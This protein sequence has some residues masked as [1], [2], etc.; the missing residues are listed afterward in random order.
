[1]SES[2]K[3]W[4][5]FV[6]LPSPNVS[7][8]ELQAKVIPGRKTDYIAKGA[9]GEPIVML[10]VPSFHTAKPSL[11]LRHI[12]IEY[13]QE[14]RI[15]EEGQPIVVGQF[16]AIACSS[17]NPALY[18]LFV[19]SADALVG[20][21]PIE[22]TAAQVEGCVKAFVELFRRLQHPGLRTIKGLWAELFLIASS[23]S[24]K[25]MVAAWR[26]DIN[27]KFDFSCGRTHIEVKSSELSQR[28]HEFSLSQLNSAGGATI[29]IASIL[30][31]RSSGGIGV[32]T[33]ADH[34]ASKLSTRPD[35]ATKLWTNVAQALGEDFGALS[36]VM[37]DDAYAGHSLKFLHMDTV[38]SLREPLMPEILDVRLRIDI[39]RIA[40]ETAVAR[41]SVESLL[42]RTRQ[43]AGYK[44]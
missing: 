4:A 26:T 36:D 32:L 40:E 25:D 22:P 39:S 15:K 41:N 24:P 18:E 38:P 3:L 27:E 6:A 30:L 21:T 29:Y 35:L 23:K 8:T 16:V 12:R 2:A 33:L 13:A 11:Q 5:T 10:Q 19:R 31:R 37:F 14:C 34:V 28:V 44:T 1:M 9:S 42:A 20:S 7:S 43:K 17:D